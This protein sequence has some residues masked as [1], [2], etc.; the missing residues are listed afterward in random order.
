[1][2]DLPRESHIGRLHKRNRSFICIRLKG[3]SETQ[4]VL[5]IS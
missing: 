3:G 4:M 1:M 5:R 2:F